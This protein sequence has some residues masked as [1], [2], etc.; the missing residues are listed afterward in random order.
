V[1]FIH[2]DDNEVSNL[3]K[4]CDEIFGEENFICTFIWK[5]R[6]NVDS[7][8]KNGASVDHEYVLT[9]GKQ[10]DA[11]IRG[12]DKDLEKY[13]NPDNDSKG[14]WMS[15]NMVGLATKEQRPNLHYDLIDPKSGINYGCPITGWRYEPIRMKQ[16]IEKNEVLFP[17]SPEGRP[18]RKKFFADLQSEFTGKSSILETVYNTNA[19]RE[20]RDLFNGK[21]YFDFPKPTDLIKE[22]VTQKAN[23]FKQEKDIQPDIIL[24]F[25]SGSATTAHAVLDLNKQDSGNHK[26]ILVQLPEPCAPDSEAFKAGYKTIADIGKERIR[27]VI[28]KITTENNPQITQKDADKEQ[29][30]LFSSDNLCTSAQSADTPS[31]DLGFKVLKLDKSN[32]RQW[33]PLPPSTPPEKIAEQMELHIDHINPK[34]SSEDLLYEILLKAGYKPTDTIETKTIAGKTVFAVSEGAF[35]LCLED[36]VT[37]E[38]IDAIADLEPMQFVCLDLA[39]HGNDQLKANAVQTFAARNMQKE[40]H[41][42]I[43]FKTV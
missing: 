16:L 6:Q 36:S 32:F 20:L 7:R 23:T 29:A 19:T 27:R 38:L 34:A 39:F 22:I 17:K 42:Q 5:R 3:R 12:G 24:D 10:T 40:K 18:R 15:D 28:Q 11:K 1:I 31:P 2:I 14:N 35:L 43:I 4:M 30:D 41:N 33:Q 13:S 37:K 8:S 26:F 21:D 9:F 25:F